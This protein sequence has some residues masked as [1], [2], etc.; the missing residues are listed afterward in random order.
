MK[1]CFATEVTYDNYVNRIK[2]SSLKDYLNSGLSAHD[3]HYYIS[4]NRINCFKEYIDHSHIHVFDIE[5]LRASRPKS[6]ALEIFPENPK[7][8]YPSKYPWNCRRFIIERAAEEGFDYIVYLDADSKFQLNI[9]SQQIFD[10]LKANFVPNTV[11]TNSAIFKYVNK[12]PDDVFNKHPQHIAH[13][14]FNFSD[15]QYDSLDGPCQVFIGN[16]NKDVLRLVSNWHTLAEFGY[17]SDFGYRN[18]KHGNLS[19]VIPMSDFQ[20]KWNGFPFHPHHTPEDRY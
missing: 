16:T 14:G 6:Q 9:T 5:K 18:N 2:Q 10:N 19:F 1:V 17:E 7:G 4:T 8:L 3:V 20:L 12:T 11:Q 15:E 13:F